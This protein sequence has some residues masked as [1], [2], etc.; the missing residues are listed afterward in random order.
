[1]IRFVLAIVVM[2]FVAAVGTANAQQGRIYD[3]TRGSTYAFG[4]IDDDS[5]D[6]DFSGPS[7]NSYDDAPR[8]VDIY[9]STGIPIGT[10]TI[11]ESTGEVISNQDGS[12][13]GTWQ[14]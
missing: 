11:V 5:D 14:Q 12:R 6:Y 2:T 1:M 8:Q 9:G 10:G 13:L 7:V 4:E 3:H